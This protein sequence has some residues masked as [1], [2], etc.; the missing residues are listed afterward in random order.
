M[1]KV[2]IIISVLFLFSL[3]TD[4]QT[5]KEPKH[6]GDWIAGGDASEF[7]LHSVMEYS[8]LLLEENPNGKLIIRIC[9]SEDIKT[10]FVKTSINPLSASDYNKYFLHPIVPYENIYISKYSECAGKSGSVYNQY[11]FVPEKSIFKYDEIVTVNKIN[12]TK[13]SIEEFD[14]ESNK[15]K[16]KNYKLLTKEFE[17]M[18]EVFVNNLAANP[19]SKGFIIHNSKSS[20]IKKNIK[21]VVYKLKEN[22]IKPERYEVIKKPTIDWNE[23]GKAYFERNDKKYF[24][25][26]SIIE[27]KK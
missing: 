5:L 19:N 9:S 1:R 26:F 25:S 3:T 17:K 18:T 8:Q 22:G 4:A 13:E 10:A 6:L 16:R 27:I 23:K 11:W 24:P 7:L 12:Y 20:K 15:I 14:Y 21:K 2:I